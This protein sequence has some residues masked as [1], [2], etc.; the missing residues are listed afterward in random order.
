MTRAFVAIRPPAQVLDAIEARVADVAMGA[1]RATTR[2]QWHLTVQF[3]GDAADI[4]AVLAAL[5]LGPLDIGGGAIR[6]G[7]ADALGTRRR[8][9]TLVLRLHDGDA[10]ARA[11]AAQVESRLASL[12][13]ARAPGEKAYVP[14]LTLARFRAPTDLRP[15]C[16]AIGPEPVG[17]AW[18]VEEI[19]L[20]ESRLRPQ[21]AQHVDRGRLRFTDRN[22][23]FGVRFPLMADRPPDE[24]LSIVVHQATGM[25]AA[26]AGCD[27]TEAFARLTIRAAAA[28]QTRH[29]MALDVLDRVTRFNK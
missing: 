3:L 8:A 27:V 13:H 6:L 24:G 9:R 22:I 15:L 1:G 21:G 28:G 16:G 18:S 26:Q 23:R 5:A 29:E 25:I 10:W 17:D 20:Y 19:V 14:H 2:D 12:G 7:G 11:L 4:D